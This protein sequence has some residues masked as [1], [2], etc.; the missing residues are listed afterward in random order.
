[1]V[2]CFHC[3]HDALLHSTLECNCI[4]ISN[5]VFSVFHFYQMPLPYWCKALLL[6]YA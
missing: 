6:H 3:N 4:I 2:V 5:V 1:M